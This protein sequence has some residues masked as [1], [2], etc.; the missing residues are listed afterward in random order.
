MPEPTE[1]LSNLGGIIAIGVFGW[2]ILVVAIGRNKDAY[3]DD[4]LSWPQMAA[5]T[6]GLILLPSSLRVLSDNDAVGP[7]T[8][9][10]IVAGLL[11]VGYV[12]VTCLEWKRPRPRPVLPAWPPVDEAG[13]GRYTERPLRGKRD[14]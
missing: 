3:P 4:R 12:L 2:A 5:R 11:L 1:P 13:A 7:L 14:A 9:L 10:L 8:L 6:V